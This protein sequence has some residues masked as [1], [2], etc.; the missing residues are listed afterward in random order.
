MSRPPVRPITREESPFGI[1][2]L[3][4]SVTDTKGHIRSGN[5]VFVRVSKFTEAELIGQPHNV[6]RH[7]DMPRAVFQLLWD[8]IKS[9]REIAAFVKNRAKDGSYYWVMATVAPLGDR[10]VSVRFK[11]SSPLLAEVEAVY[12]DC[13]AAEHELQ[14]QGAPHR[15]LVEASMTRLLERLAALGF[16]SY[17]AFMHHALTTEMRSRMD[18]L[19]QRTSGPGPILSAT[20]KP[21]VRSMLESGRVVERYLDRLVANLHRFDNL[22]TSLRQKADFVRTLADD[23]RLFSLNTMLAA[24][25]LEKAAT[26]EQVAS[27]MRECTLGIADQ[28]GALQGHVAEAG[29]MVRSFAFEVT[30][31]GVQAM[32]V[33]AFA[34]EQLSGG[35]GEHATVDED[36]RDLAL[37][38]DGGLSKMFRSVGVLE[39]TLGRVA[40]HVDGLLGNLRAL[41]VLQVTGRV[42][43]ARMVE[44]SDLQF[45]FESLRE[46]I[47][48]ARQQA[49]ELAE[50][51]TVGRQAVP[52]QE[53][54]VIKHLAM[55]MDRS[56]YRAA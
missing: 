38:L 4:F 29:S 1:E 16:D 10:Y 19:R 6:I 23:I 21:H 14:E 3:F 56:R 46:R 39:K 9:G 35:G 40:D 50:A 31:A 32:M 42:E 17:D 15:E 54:D 48:S 49:D 37:C 26:L 22:N 51:V 11:P 41:G 18:V 27:L 43:A 44:A 36:V 12:R 24:S 13:V 7:P 5:S 20:D 52:A 8:Y 45:L 28:I 34:T 2:E 25:R 30:V 53:A 33:T 55:L 47:A